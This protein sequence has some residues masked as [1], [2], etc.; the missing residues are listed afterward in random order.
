MHDH[1]DQLQHRQHLT[2]TGGVPAAGALDLPDSGIQVA[3][4]EPAEGLG[5]LPAGVPDQP[6]AR[7]DLGA[8]ARQL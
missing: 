2:A 8:T 5:R 4:T 3:D 7:K 6:I 1:G